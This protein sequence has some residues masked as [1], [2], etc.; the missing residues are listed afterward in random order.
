MRLR[1]YSLL[2]AIT[3][4]I[5]AS[6]QSTRL[7]GYVRDSVTQFPVAGA[8]ITNVTTKKKVVSNDKGAFAIEASPNDFFYILSRSYRPETLT[9]SLFLKDSLNII[10]SP[11]GNIL[12]SVTVTAGYTKY[13][14][15]SIKRRTD[16]EQNIGHTLNTI[17]SS[18][19]PGFGVTVNL[20]RFFKKKYRNQKK[21]IEIFEA[22]EKAAYVDYRFSPY[23]VQHYTGFKGE[24]LR[25]FMNRSMPEYEWLRR[26]SSN[27]DV[28]FYIND[29]L[30][31]Y[32][33]IARP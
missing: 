11:S 17:A 29:K 5:S 26:H 3:V 19:G 23:I 2:I 33:S 9:Y 16:F 28:M 32:R 14:L 21:D 7:F 25:D 18:H 24:T 8:T 12:P 6:A 1:I 4:V 27:E 22:L 30:K 31:A 20:D 15:D 10:L 13:Q